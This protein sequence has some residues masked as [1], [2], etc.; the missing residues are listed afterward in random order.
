MIA[1]LASL[2]VILALAGWCA[3]RV[4]ARYQADLAATRAQLEGRSR[5]V[6]TA[7]GPIEV[8]TVGEGL[9]VLIAHGGAGGFDQGL[10]IADSYLG[11]GFQV[12]A[13]SR[14]GYLRTPLADDSSAAA[15]ADAY[16]HLLDVLGLE[17][18]AIVGVSAGGPSSLQFALRHPDRCIALVMMAAVSRRV[19]PRP[20]GIYKSDFAYWFANTYLRSMALE[21]VGVTAEL[22]AKL[23]PAERD[24]L[25][26]F[27]GTMSPFSLRLAGQLH[28]IEEW[29]DEA[30]WARDYP[31]D[32]IATPT[33]VVHAVD[34]DVIPFS[35]AEYTAREIEGARLVSLPSGGHMRVGQT[36]AA[37]AEIIR[38]LL[39]QAASPTTTAA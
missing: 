24:T 29:A 26:A 34:D 1:L 25:D 30:R 8:A 5:I 17:R 3:V 2:V 27:F 15:Q 16:A 4:R 38:F 23:T 7:S 37:G 31:L 12:I 28:D 13:P 18:A 11:E 6:E 10:Y 19:P 20:T 9:P 14:F 35:H 32:R 21:K 36:A 33:L 22:Q 39:E